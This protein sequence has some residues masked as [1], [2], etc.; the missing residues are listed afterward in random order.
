MLDEETDQCTSDKPSNT[1]LLPD[2]WSMRQYDSFKDKYDGLIMRDKKLGCL[3]CVKFD[4]L[5]MKGEHI[6]IEW[7]KCQVVASG[8]NKTIQQA[9]LRNKK[10]DNF[11]SKAHAICV[12]QVDACENDAITKNMDKANEKYIRSTCKVFKTV[13]S[14]AKSS[15]PFSDVEDEIEL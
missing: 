14:L 8:K 2:C 13:Y 9:A 3:H 1:L 11:T 6:S 15:R 4:Y 12:N 5:N 10:K 7:K